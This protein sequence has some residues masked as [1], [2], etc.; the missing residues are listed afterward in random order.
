MHALLDALRR[1]Y[2]D[3]EE[4]DAITELLG[5]GEIGGRD[6]GNAFDINR[7][8]IDFGAEGQARQDRELLRGVVALDIEAR[9][10]LGV[11]KALRL[12][13]AFGKRQAVLLHAGEDII[14]GAVEDSVDAL[15]GISRHPFAQRLHDGNGPA[16][17]RFEV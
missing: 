12:L 17:G 15:E 6:R 10:G 1:L 5:C 3:A 4:L 2:R 11:T 7:L 14:A 16:Y 9:I 8:L 13:E